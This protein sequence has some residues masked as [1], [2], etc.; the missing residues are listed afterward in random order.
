VDGQ[1]IDCVAAGELNTTSRGLLPQRKL[2]RHRTVD[3]FTRN[4]G[5]PGVS[6]LMNSAWIASSRSLPFQP[7]S[8]T[9][10]SRKVLNQVLP[11]VPGV[12]H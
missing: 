8:K 6:E 9:P 10:E 1:R 11:G 7:V 3:S 12:P 2:S 5:F 4:N